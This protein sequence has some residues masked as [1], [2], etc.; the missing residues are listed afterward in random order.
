M[1]YPRSVD[2][3]GLSLMTSRTKALL[4]E[5]QSIGKSARSLA[6]QN[7]RVGRHSHFPS[8]SS[9]L[10]RMGTNMLSQIATDQNISP[11]R[12]AKSLQTPG[13]AAVWLIFYLV[14]L[15]IAISSPVVSAAIE[16][17]ALIAE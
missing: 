8:V 3:M 10:C 16:F 15:H 17:A 4:L 5:R 12:S 11:R 1:A 2:L 6:P 9:W 14:A 7:A 13:I